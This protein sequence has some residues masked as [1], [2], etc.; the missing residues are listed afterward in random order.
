MLLAKGAV[1][2]PRVLSEARSLRS[3][4]YEVTV[5][6]WDRDDEY[7]AEE[8]VDG[9]RFVRARN[10]PWMRALPSDLLRLRPWWRLAR[11]RARTI[12]DRHPV[13]VVH[14]H[15]LDTL[16][17]GVA[18]KADLGVPLVYDAHEI[19]AYMVADDLPWPVPGHF[20][21]KEARLVDDVDH[22][23]TVSPVLADHYR[24]LADVPAT[25]VMNAKTVRE[26][27][28]APPDNDTFTVTYLGKLVPAR[29]IHGLVEAVADLDDVR[30]VLAGSGP[31]RY[32][33]RLRDR[34]AGVP[35]V[36]YLGVVPFEEVLPTTRASDL[37]ACLFSA[38]H[39]LLRV[40]MPNKLFEAMATG[41]PLI[42][43][44]G[45]YI[46]EFVRDHDI[47]TVVDLDVDAVR[48]GIEAMRD[49][50]DRCRRLGR[51]ALDHALAQYNWQAQAD[52]LLAVYQDLVGDGAERS[53][54]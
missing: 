14:A 12:D 30:L 25:V 50:P 37:V 28:Y 38:S 18:L 24:D 11:R 44:Q 42:V 47:G 1:H 49:D 6:G 20:H 41:R 19:W 33:R 27:T 9:I 2:D 40:G 35:S 54:L 15:D 46:A 16:P 29:F 8:T 51:N 3:E 23:V 26:T 17:A 13:D 32:V 48:T 34:I 5:L 4:G 31:D 45:T 10:T 21:R 39:P 52:K 53:D 43:G 36:E 7:P 22:L